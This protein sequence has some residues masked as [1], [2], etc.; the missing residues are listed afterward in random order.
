M[1]K[2]PQYKDLALYEQLFPLNV[3]AMAVSE[4]NGPLSWHPE[5]SVSN[6]LTLNKPDQ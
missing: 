6:E 5:R 2:L 4:V 3:Q 1:V